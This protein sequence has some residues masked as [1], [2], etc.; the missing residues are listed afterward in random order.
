LALS[1][2]FT[3]IPYFLAIE[4]LDS[5]GKTAIVV[6]SEVRFPVSVNFAATAISGEDA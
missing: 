4:Y 2:S 6:C 5:L 3:V 1:N